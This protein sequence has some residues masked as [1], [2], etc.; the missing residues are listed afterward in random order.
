LKRCLVALGWL[1][2][3]AHASP[4]QVHRLRLRVGHDVLA[5]P[6]STVP[7][8]QYLRDALLGA[9]SERGFCIDRTGDFEA[10]LH[11]RS[12]VEADG[13][14]VI[15]LTIDNE[16]GSQIDELSETLPSLPASLVAARRVVQPL[17]LDLE[18]S[19]PLQDLAPGNFPCADGN[20]TR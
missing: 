5:D 9:L 1:F 7:Q 19:G 6:L 2:G 4:E 13:T 8:A 12:Q 3:C 20:S 17:L 10:L 16:A 15:T 14:A 18:H 11:L